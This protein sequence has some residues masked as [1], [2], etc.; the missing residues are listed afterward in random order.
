MEKKIGVFICECGPNIA[1]KIDIDEVIKAISPLNDV[2]VVQRYKLLCSEEGKKY[3]VEQIKKQNITHLVCAAC[4]PRDHLSTFM[5][6]CETAGIN[7]YLFQLANIREQCA[8][9]TNDKIEATDKAIRLTKAAIARVRIQAP[10]E[11]KH[12]TSNP[13][14]LVIGG[15]ITGIE[16]ALQL[17]DSTRN[18]YI[19]EKTEKLGGLLTHFEK[20]YPDMRSS[21]SFIKEKLEAM[22]NHKNITVFLNT[23]IEDILGFFG[24]FQTTLRDQTSEQSKTNL[25]VGAI[26]FAT[27]S[28]LFDP[29][30]FPQYGYSKFDNVVTSLEFEQ[31]NLKNNIHLKNGKV[32]KSIAIVHCVG[33]N[34]KG[35]C[36]QV[37]CLYSLKFSRYIKDKLPDSTVTHYYRDL[38]IPGKAN[39]QFFKQT[40]QAKGD[41][42]RAEQISLSKKD[43]QLIVTY[44]DAAGGKKN[45]SVDMVIL[46]PALQSPPDIS[47]L[48]AMT[49]ISQDRSGFITEEHEKLKPVSTTTEG[50]YIAGCAQ[51]PKSISESITQA[52]AVA[53]KILS[54]LIPGKELEP[55]VKVAQISESFCIGCK[56]C[57][58]VCSYGCITFDE[59]KRIAVVNEVICR[60][61]G[62]CVAAC[63]SGAATLKHFTSD[64]IYEELKEAAP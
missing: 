11:Q 56:T 12:I 20:L 8:W 15:G 17:A 34:Q 5:D 62:N 58:D 29:S 14:V 23:E 33:R 46:S 36:S 40:Q 31:M 63:P 39:Q 19:V 49:R 7:P 43:E 55:E 53:G 42:I 47:R 18:V 41:M 10:L 61:C 59:T 57:I 37:C 51:G 50:V 28:T 25:D 9:I 4:S 16:T 54:V 22:H 21:S 1:E 2:G 60:G 27:G 24:N 45:Q 64:Q 3:L 32:P 26:V 35:Y 44:H 30:A 38:C 6:V 48:A 52:Q 13:D